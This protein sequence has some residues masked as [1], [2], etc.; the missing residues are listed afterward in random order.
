MDQE[1]ST[2]S[3]VEFLDACRSFEIWI[4]GGWGVDA[5]LGVQ[6]RVHSDLDIIINGSEFEAF[7][8][9][10]RSNGYSREHSDATVFVSPAG[11]AVDVHCVRFDARGYGIFDLPDGREWP[12][13]PSAFQGN[14]IIGDAPVRCLSPEAQVQCHAQGYEPTSKDLSD[15]QAL[16]ERFQVVLPLQLC[17]RRINSS[18]G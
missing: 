14:G 5:L 15:M 2:A 13:P 18:A 8:V 1:A 7:T 4:D 11:L 12:F 9:F 10:M 16:Q 17:P 6:S 3:V